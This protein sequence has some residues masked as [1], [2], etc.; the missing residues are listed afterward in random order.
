M[1]STM[2]ESSLSRPVTPGCSTQKACITVPTITL[3][4]DRDAVS[5]RPA[6]AGAAAR[7]FRKSLRL[8]APDIQEEYIRD[9]LSV[10]TNMKPQVVIVKCAEAFVIRSSDKDQA[11]GCDDRST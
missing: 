8:T 5:G 11:A 1:S 6:S 9:R 3:R 2:P 4:G 7:V 10:D